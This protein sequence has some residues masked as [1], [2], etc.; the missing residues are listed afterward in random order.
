MPLDQPADV[1]ALLGD[2]A[3]LAAADAAADPLDRART[4]G[5]LAGVALRAMEARDLAARVEALEA[6]LKQRRAG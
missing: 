1:L 3:A 4:L 5:Y 2:A 6:V